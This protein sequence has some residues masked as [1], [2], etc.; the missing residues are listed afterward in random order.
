MAAA[1]NAERFIK[2]HQ[3]VERYLQELLDAPQGQSFRSMV[4][5]A[6]ARSAEVRACKH[7][8]HQFAELRN[9]I[10]HQDGLSERFIA[11]PTLEVTERYE[12]IARRVTEPPKVWPR[13]AY[14]VFQL[15]VDAPLSEALELISARDISQFPVYE[16]RAFRGLLTGRCIARWLAHAGAVVEVGQTPV[17]EVLRYEETGGRNVAF[18]GKDA[19]ELEARE[20]F[21]QAPTRE[22]PIVEAVIITEHGEPGES[23]V[24]IIT[25]WDLLDED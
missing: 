17:G 25:P 4:D 18:I 1:S 16:G 20:L 12:T 6:A 19:T 21:S 11:E 5:G 15:A 24:G 9:A 8:L 7:E 3:R 13:F 22:Q 10:V 2:A 23:P 14:P